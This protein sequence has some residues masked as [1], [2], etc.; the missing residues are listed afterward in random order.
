MTVSNASV[1]GKKLLNAARIISSAGAQIESMIEILND[2]LIDT[3]GDEKKKVRVDADWADK[4]I[5]SAG[6][7]LITSY[8]WDIALLKGRSNKPYAHLAIQ[9][10]L[11]NED[12]EFRIQGWEPSIY[13]MYAPG[14]DEFESDS[15]RLHRMLEEN[16][17]LDEDR[18]WRWKEFEENDSWLFALPLVKIN[19]EDDLVQQ[20]VQ[21]VKRLI[22]GET[23]SEAFP[24]D[25]VAFHFAQEG[26]TLRILAD[27]PSRK[28][29]R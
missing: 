11:Y 18:L 8:F 14:E 15:N 1:N 20:I 29:S 5:R 3:L 13:V 12:E 17:R 9:V 2:K 7:W 22:A 16:A 4:S 26:D 28:Q 23:A 6:N 19:C 27:N 24:S 21:P 10:M 25:S